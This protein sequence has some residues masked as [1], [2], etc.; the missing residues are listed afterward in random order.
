MTAITG[1]FTDYSV[2]TTTAGTTASAY[3]WKRGYAFGTATNPSSASRTIAYYNVHCST[4]GTLYGPYVLKDQDGV[5]VAQTIGVEE[6]QELPSACAG[7]TILVAV[8]AAAAS[9]ANM[10]FHFER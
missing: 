1:S 8:T 2:A 5:A 7:A 10:L 9:T 4:D 6:S 3:M